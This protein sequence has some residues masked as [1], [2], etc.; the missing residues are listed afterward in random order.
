[1]DL[2][3]KIELCNDIV[4]GLCKECRT[5]AACRESGNCGLQNQPIATDLLALMRAACAY[6]DSH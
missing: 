6:A 5:F 3:D 2:S 4:C 1:M